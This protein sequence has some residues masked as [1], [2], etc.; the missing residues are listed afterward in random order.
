MFQYYTNYSVLPLL[1]IRA[2]CGIYILLYMFL[3]YIYIFE[4]MLCNMF[5]PLPPPSFHR[6]GRC[7]V[8]FFLAFLIFI[9][10]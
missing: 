7:L 10:F 9:Y 6:F 3:Q 4:I 1:I 5:L 8:G 2:A